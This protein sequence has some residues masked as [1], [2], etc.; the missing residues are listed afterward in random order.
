LFRLKSLC[1][2]GWRNLQMKKSKK[3]SDKLDKSIFKK[4]PEILQEYLKTMRQHH[5]VASKKGKGS[6]KRKEKYNHREDD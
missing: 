1:L 4:N 3:S 5:V 6:Y 2:N